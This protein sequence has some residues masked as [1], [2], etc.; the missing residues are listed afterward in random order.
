MTKRQDP[1]NADNRKYVADRYRAAAF[2]L[3]RAARTLREVTAEIRASRIKI[4]ATAL[5]DLREARDI[6][7]ELPIAP[8]AA[9]ASKWGAR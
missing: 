4:A 7:A 8:V 2:D 1:A 6:L 3:L 5:T 9:D